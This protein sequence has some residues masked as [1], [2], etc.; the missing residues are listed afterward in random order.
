[1]VNATKANGSRVIAI[2]TTVVRSLEQAALW[3]MGTGSKLLNPTSGWADIF[4]VPGYD[5]KLVEGMVTNFHLP[6][7]SVLMLVSALAGHEKLKEAYDEAIKNSY[8]FYSF[9]DAMLI[10]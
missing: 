3:G 5:F 1:M 6:R 10:L 2:G 4:I 8:R 7:S 9:G